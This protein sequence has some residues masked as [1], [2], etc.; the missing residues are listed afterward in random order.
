MVPDCIDPELLGPVNMRADGLFAAQNNTTPGR[1]EQKDRFITNLIGQGPQFANLL[2]EPNLVRMV[3]TILGEDC[4]LSSA[5][6]RDVFNGCE[7]QLL[8]TD[9]LLYAGRD[10]WFK[11]PVEKQLSLVAVVALGDQVASRGTTVLFPKSH[12]WVET[13]DV[14]AQ[15]DEQ[16][17]ATIYNDE[18][19]AWAREHKGADAIH[20]EM[21]AGSV[22]IWLGAI[23]HAGGAYG[24]ANGG[25]RRAA[26]FN[27]CRGI[28]RQQENQMAGIS[29][30]QAAAMP[31]AVQR[32]L[33]YTICD[34]GLGYAGPSLDPALLLG[35]GGQALAADNATRM[36][37]KR[38]K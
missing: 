21:K 32:L 37:G 2:A 24:D 36:A 8:H 26:L 4:L 35:E 14:L 3:T 29:H 6:I 20:V 22:V 27:F 9:D 15:P 13:P 28:F 18:L 5:S 1:P 7:E 11:R 12:M 16:T 38:G 25:T 17:Q 23:W 10:D 33:G 19:R 34:T 31:Q 30:E